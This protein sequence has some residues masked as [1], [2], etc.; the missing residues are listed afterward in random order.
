MHQ[1]PCVRLALISLRCLVGD[2]MSSL[3]GAFCDG[4]RHLR[5]VDSK[6]M[7]FCSFGE[8]GSY[9]QLMTIVLPHYLCFTRVGRVSH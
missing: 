2:S 6:E 9:T 7:G 3:S 4:R 1:S 5:A 8:K